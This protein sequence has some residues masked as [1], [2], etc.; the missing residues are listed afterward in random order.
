MCHDGT[1]FLS[2]HT[3]SSRV[4]AE[5]VTA[6]KTVRYLSMVENHAVSVSKACYPLAVCNSTR[7]YRMIDEIKNIV[8]Q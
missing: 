8:C 2:D 5:S 4:F 1:M 3:P 6:E 7:E